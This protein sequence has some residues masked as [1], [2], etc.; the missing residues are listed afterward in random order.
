[1]TKIQNML[2]RLLA[3][4]ELFQQ[5]I[6]SRRPGAVSSLI[7]ALESAK[8]ALRGGQALAELVRD[9]FNSRFFIESAYEQIENALG[10]I[11]HDADLKD[12]L[13]EIIGLL[14][15]LSG[16]RARAR[17]AQ[18]NRNAAFAIFED[19]LKRLISWDAE[20]I[21]RN[22]SSGYVDTEH[23]ICGELSFNDG[24]GYIHVKTVFER[25]VFYVTPTNGRTETFELTIEEEREFLAAMAEV[26]A[27]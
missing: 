10:M 27:L 11:N 6:G 18:E 13:A 23:G 17:A 20:T 24:R 19:Y 9:D 16:Q 15:E 1:M 14:A 21:D 7:E 4:S 12:Q 22:L 26:Y 8:D 5:E 25:T 2:S 3:D